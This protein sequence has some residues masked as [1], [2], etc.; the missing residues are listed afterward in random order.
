M[1]RIGI[2]TCSNCARE[3]NCSSVVCFADM[4]KRRGFFKCY[5]RDEP[6]DFV[7]LAHC[8]GCPTAVAP[9]KILKRVC[10]LVEYKID[11]LHFSYCMTALCPFLGAYEKEIRRVYPELKIVHGTHQPG[12]TENF[13]KAVKEMLCPTVRIPQDMNDLIRERFVFRTKK[14]VLENKEGKFKHESLEG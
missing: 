6:I 2:M 10:S 3:T 1:A 11:V 14:E 13:K 5:S 12:D 9:G 4:R 7:G 8:A